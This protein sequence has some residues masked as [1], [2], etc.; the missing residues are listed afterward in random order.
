MRRFTLIILVTVWGAAIGGAAQAPEQ[1]LLVIDIQGFYFEGGAV[2]L[3]GSEPAAETAGELVEAFRTR[4]WPVIHVQH[5]PP[6]AEGPAVDI[7]PVAYRN[8]PAGA[9]RNG[10]TLIGKRRANAFVGTDLGKTL[11]TLGVTEVV[12]VGMQTHMCVE[13]ASRAAADLGYR[14]TVVGDACATRDLEFGGTTVAAADVHASTLASLDGTYAR[15]VDSATFLS[16]LPS[17][18]GDVQ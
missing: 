10:E 5:L 15:V 9:P 4:G 17:A 14:V 8:H 13:A 11:E 1:A 6:D 7:E 16:G 18:E 2:A 3:V 12:V